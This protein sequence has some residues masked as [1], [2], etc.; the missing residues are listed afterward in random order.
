MK[1]PS[2]LLPIAST[3]DITRSENREA[4]GLPV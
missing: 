2:P 1:A 3:K 4:N